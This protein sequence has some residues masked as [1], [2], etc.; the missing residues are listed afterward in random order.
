MSIFTVDA[1]SAA[2]AAEAAT[3]AVAVYDDRKMWGRTNV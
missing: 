3:T 1:N 2:A